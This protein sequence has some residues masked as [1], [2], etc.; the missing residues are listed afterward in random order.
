MGV[1]VESFFLKG[2][3]Q[4]RHSFNIYEAVGTNTI[5]SVLVG[6]I[7]ICLYSLYNRNSL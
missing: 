4:G 6:H 2:K 5:A 7:R 1:L 3:G